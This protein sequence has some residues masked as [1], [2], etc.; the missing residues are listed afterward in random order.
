VEGSSPE[1]AAI[2]AFFAPRAAGWEEKFPDDGPAF[3][4]A[5]EA[6]D[7]PPGG[8]ALDAACGTGRA[9]PVLRRAVGP[10]GTVIGLDITLEMLSEADRRG[11][12]ATA[13]LVLGDVC[14]LPLPDGCVDAILGAGLLPHLGDAAAGL[15]ELGR[16]TRPRGR[17]ALFHPIGRAALAARHGGSPDPEDIRAEPRIRKL[18]NDTG[19]E[20]ELVDDAADRYLV[21]ATRREETS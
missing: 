18:L 2:R 5:V 1:L 14:R 4:A 20:A 15:A 7:P 8:V 6:M 19:W 10:A 9:L 11:R 3:A 13:S 16:V 17:L 21:I 12:R